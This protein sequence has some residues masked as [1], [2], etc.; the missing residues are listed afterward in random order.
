[1]AFKKAD[2]STVTPGTGIDAFIPE[3][4]S[5]RLLEHLN[6]TH[7]YAALMNRDYEGEISAMGDTVHI[8][9]IG[10]ITIKNYDG[11]DIA[12]PEE[13]D[14]NTTNLVIDQGDYFNFMIKDVDN[15]Q[16]NPKLMDAAMRRAAYGINDTADAYLADIL[17]N[18]A[19]GKIGDDTTPI[20][21]TAATAYENLVDLGTKLTEANVPMT[22][23]WVVIPPWFHGLLQKDSRFVG[24]GTNYN[25]A[26]LENGLVGAAAGFQI[27]LSNN[28]PNT[29]GAKYK[30]IAGTNAAGSYAEQLTEMVAYRPE[31]NFADAIKGLHVYGAKV[32]QHKALAV[33]TANKA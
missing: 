4:W 31:K 14:S 32:V 25:Q 13:L 33:L 29:S 7:V 15:A 2:G 5:A 22:G 3:I 12:A 10:A 8:N 17:A 21:P 28:V 20:V 24:N 26:I 27:H 23:R 30:I 11:S 18:G 19:D 9:Q 16:T 1:M 6:K